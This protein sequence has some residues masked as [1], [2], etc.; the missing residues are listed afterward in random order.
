MLHVG[1]KLRH[2]YTLMK[3]RF[4]IL[5]TLASTVLIGQNQSL[6]ESE[7]DTIS[8]LGIENLKELIIERVECQRNNLYTSDL[9][10]ENCFDIILID[11]RAQQIDYQDTSS[12]ND[13]KNKLNILTM[14]KLT[15]TKKYLNDKVKW[16]S[17]IDI[18]TDQNNKIKPSEY[19]IE[20]PSKRNKVEKRNQSGELIF[21]YPGIM[22]YLDIH[23]SEFII[24][25]DDLN[26]NEMMLWI[27]YDDK[28]VEF[29]LYVK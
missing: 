29:N 5:L 19:K 4:I 11:G 16:S 10:Q 26:D 20:I 15:W 23:Q 6:I 13:F 2:K 14:R 1:G 8:G 3:I 17:K 28:K 12:I 18:L 9:N 22:N 27:I 21:Q 7:F 25:D 24:N